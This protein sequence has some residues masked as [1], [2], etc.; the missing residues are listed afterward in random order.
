MQ[1]KIS[2]LVGLILFWEETKNKQNVSKIYF[3]LLGNNW[4][5]KW[6]VAV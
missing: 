6:S 2:T 1:R 5:G 3:I 4:E